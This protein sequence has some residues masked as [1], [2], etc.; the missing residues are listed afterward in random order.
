MHDT[1]LAIGAEFFRIYARE[2]KGVIVELGSQNVNGSLRRVA[3]AA[4]EY[5]GIDTDPGPGVDMVVKPGRRLPLESGS[6]DIVT[7]TSAFE[8]D[9]AFWQTFVEL[10]R[11]TKP[12]GFVYVNAPSNGNVHRFP[13][14]CWRFYP[15]AGIALEM[16]SRQKRV[17]V[18]LVESFIG[19]RN[20]DIWNDFAAVFRRGERGAIPPTRLYA[21]FEC[22][23]V[24]DFASPSMLFVDPR[25]QD[26]RLG[27]LE[28]VKAATAQAQLRDE[29][30][31]RDNRIAVLESERERL[32]TE[33]ARLSG[34]NVHLQQVLAGLERTK[35]VMTDQID[36]LNDGLASLDARVQ[37]AERL[38]ERRSN[39]TSELSAQ[40]SAQTSALQ[41]AL[42]REKSRGDGLDNELSRA[43][44]KATKLQSALASATSR[45]ECL[46]EQLEQLQVAAAQSTRIALAESD[47]LREQMASRDKH[48][49]A[50]QG[51]IEE[52]RAQGLHQRETLQQ[53]IARRDLHIEAMQQEV[54]GLEARIRAME[55]QILG[56]DSHI[57][58]IHQETLSR[59]TRFHAAQQQILGRDAHIA[60]LQAALAQTHNECDRLRHELVARD[61]RIAELRMVNMQL[62]QQVRAI[63]QSGVLRSSWLSRTIQALSGKAASADVVAQSQRLLPPPRSTPYGTTQE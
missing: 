12:S 53:E 2:P 20:A 5:I 47:T 49:L 52:A 57:Q 42:A 61:G 24:Y 50:L 40:L 62:I 45:C 60:G 15:D 46:E 6:V 29:M 11:I 39:E 22:R 3:P 38:A 48:V 8:H 19:E 44:T 14:D 31:A 55:Q 41:A 36:R 32:E 13:R 25:P 1:A 43:S 28:R 26:V 37:D 63:A 35:A 10:C 21:A 23:N 54:L 16:L 30:C 4:Y 56:R 7:A 34:E 51:A 59:E 58:A 9:P 33:A 18:T 17:P 27:E